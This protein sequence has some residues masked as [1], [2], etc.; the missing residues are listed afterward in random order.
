[1]DNE[2]NTHDGQ[3]PKKKKKTRWI[4]LVVPRNPNSWPLNNR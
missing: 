2:E 4:S 1:M 3:E